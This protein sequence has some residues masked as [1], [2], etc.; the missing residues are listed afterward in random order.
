LLGREHLPLVSI[1]NKR[2]ADGVT[3]GRCL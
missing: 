2:A 1:R 3:D